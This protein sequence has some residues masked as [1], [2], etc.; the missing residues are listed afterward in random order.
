L[1]RFHLF[2][3]GLTRYCLASQ[4]CKPGHSCRPGPKARV[5][6]LVDTLVKAAS[7]LPLQV[8]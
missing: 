8:K 6:L 3:G 5:E 7:A 1:T 4:S 2:G